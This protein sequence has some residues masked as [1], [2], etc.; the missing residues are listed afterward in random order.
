MTDMKVPGPDNRKA[1]SEG[2]EGPASGL[3]PRTPPDHAGPP[4]RSPLHFD[5]D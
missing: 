5:G 2:R 4:G 1:S 3:P